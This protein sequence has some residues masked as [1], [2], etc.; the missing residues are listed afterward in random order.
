MLAKS[1]FIFSFVKELRLPNGQYG[2]PI[3]GRVLGNAANLKRHLLMH[4]GSKPYQCSFCNQRFR[5][6]AHL[7]RHS[8]AIHQLPLESVMIENFE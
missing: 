6:K 2:C 1:L 4:T 3:C 8:R 5:Q 7:K